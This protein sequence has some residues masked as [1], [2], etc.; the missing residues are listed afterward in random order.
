MN[1]EVIDI[2]KKNNL[3]PLSYLKK[4]NV[5]IIRDKERAYVLKLNTNNYD[6]YKY[7]LSRDFND[8]P[9][10]F[11]KEN[12]SYDLLEYIEE[13]KVNK[14]QKLNDL[15]Q[16]I[17]VL[18]RKTSYMRDISMDDVKKEYEALKNKIQEGKEYYYHLNDL[19]DQELFLSP[20]A[21]LLVRNISLI[22]YLLEY[23]NQHLD[24]YYENI[25][26]EKN[27]RISLLHNNISLDHLIINERKYLINWDKAYFNNPIYD[28]ISFYQKYYQD[29]NLSDVIKI[30]ESKNKLTILEKE[31]LIIKLAIV[32]KL[33]LSKDTF[34][35]TKELNQKL[36]FLKNIYSYC[37]QN[38]K[39][40]KEVTN[41]NK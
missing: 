14:E 16:E 24:S 15:L 37:K 2:I 30:Y 31:L 41:G 11:A 13:I 6:I 18:H 5:Y 3:H 9:E 35:D 20:D 19:I 17:A 7:L 32:P 40:I 12:T 28:L 33:I 22:Y 10:S 8:F 26:K 1:K 29:F 27:V 39:L 23:A 34:Q 25:K 36:M 38:D 4:G 21:Y